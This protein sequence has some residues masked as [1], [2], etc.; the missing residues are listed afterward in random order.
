MTG[1]SGVT[2]YRI[3]LNNDYYIAKTSANNAKIFKIEDKDITGRAPSI[4]VYNKENDEEY[5]TRTCC[6]ICG[7]PVEV[8]LGDYPYEI[9]EEERIVKKIEPLPGEG[10]RILI[11]KGREIAA[12]VN[13]EY[14]ETIIGRQ[15]INSIPDIDMTSIDE[16]RNVSRQHAMIYKEDG[17]FYLRKLSA[18]NALHVN[19]EPVIDEDVKLNDGDMI[20]LS[21]K[22]G[23]QFIAQ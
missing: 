14:D 6:G 7:A 23:L 22:Y 21:R 9:V 18:S 2:D 12:V 4:P 15:S 1:C 16:D 20:V 10:P 8:D 5:E 3:I 17:N 11:Y 13:L 19:T